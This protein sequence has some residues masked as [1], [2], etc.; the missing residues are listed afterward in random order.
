VRYGREFWQQLSA[1]VDRGSTVAEVARRY[2]VQPR[3]LSWWRWRLKRVAP[4]RPLLLP[5]VVRPSRTAAAPSSPIE[6]QIS[7][8]IIRV[9]A[10]TDVEY[11][12]RLIAALRVGC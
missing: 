12:T 6:I 11:L 5:V 8:L 7:D 10:E 4:S 2:G 1:E 3:T 9:H